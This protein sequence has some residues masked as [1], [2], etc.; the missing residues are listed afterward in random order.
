MINTSYLNDFNSPRRQI[1]GKVE[2]LGSST[3]TQSGAV[4][5]ID[6]T[7]PYTPVT[8]KIKSKN[9]LPYPYYDTT[10]TMNGITFTDNGDG[11]ITANGT[12]TYQT[13]FYIHQNIDNGLYLENNVPYTLSGVSGG[14]IDTYFIQITNNKAWK[15][16][17]GDSISFY[18]T[19]EKWFAYIV[20]KAGVTVDN[21]VFKPQVEANGKAT[22]YVPYNPAAA[23]IT[24]YGKNLV[25]Y[26]FS[27]KPGTINNITY[28]DNG[29]GTVTANGSVTSSQSYFFFFKG[30]TLKKG[31]YIFSGC[32]KG[33]NGNTYCVWLLPNGSYSGAPLDIGNGVTFEVTEDTSFDCHITIKE[34]VSFDNAV[35]AP[36]IRAESIESN[37]YEKYKEPVTY[38]PKADGTIDIT[39]YCKGTTL[40]A[41]TGV[42]IETSYITNEYKAQYLSTDNLKAIKIERQG[43]NN[44]F[45]GFGIPQ[46]AT[47]NLLDRERAINITKTDALNNFFK[48]NENDFVNSFPS[49]FVTETKRDENTNELTITAEDLLFAAAA[50]TVSEVQLG[51]YTIRSFTEAIATIM[52]L[53]LEI[54]GVADEAVFDTN[55]SDG[56]NFEGTETFREALDDVAEATQTVY[57][58]SGEKLVFKRL[59]TEAAALDIEKQHYFTLKSFPS[60]TLGTIVQATELGDNVTYAVTDGVTQYVRDNAFWDKDD[61]IIEAGANAICG[62]AAVPFECSWRGNFLLELGDKVGI[63]T[64][65]NDT[66]F[67]Y[68]LNDTITYDGGFKQVTQWSYEENKTETAS[69]P[70]TLGAV[71]KQTYAKVDKANKQIELI[72]SETSANSSEIAAIKLDTDSINSSVESLETKVN[73]QNGAIE[74]INK[75]VESTMTAEQIKYTISSELEKGTDKVTTSTGFTFDSTGLTVNKTGS[76][77]STTIT[78]DGMRVSKDN[79]EVLTANNKGV[80]AI[81]LHATTYLIIGSNSRFEDYGT[82]RTGCFWIGG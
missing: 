65:D 62:I 37:E 72:A 14:S 19:G 5:G 74:S 59:S 42:I 45:F 30:L 20:I 51:S 49:F 39:A 40:V 70:S 21:V 2:L 35:F 13:L 67:S 31:R 12:A 27:Q 54:V 15:S 57:Y 11:T 52:G 28:T 23:T 66:I 56:A 22:P 17:T 53:E 3:I 10:K 80:K 69:N 61:S 78:E 55:F 36:M 64:K 68:V 41:S 44:K 76:E 25:P 60:V 82:N 18:G 50:H 26:P 33:G 77:I 47:I 79:K 6:K 7:A 4:V 29:D 16:D 34:G 81:D 71:L 73:A 43:E 58:I 8:A 48:I 1:Q 24:K 63:T 32:P 46:K 9:I 75:K 38:K